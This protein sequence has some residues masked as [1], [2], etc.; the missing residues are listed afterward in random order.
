MPK[1][2]EIGRKLYQ[3]NFISF[4]KNQKKRKYHI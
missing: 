3:N 2:E 1:V 4:E